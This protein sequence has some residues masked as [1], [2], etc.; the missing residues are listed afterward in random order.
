VRRLV[1]KMSMSVDGYVA[2][3]RGEGDWIIRTGDP[4]GKAWV[5]E[6]LREAGAHVMGRRTYEA[7]KAYWPTSSDPLAELMNSIPK[8]VFSRSAEPGS[9]QAAGAD[10]DEARFLG[11]DLAA[12]VAT[13]KAEPGKDL[14]AQGGV[15]F[16]RSLV[17]AGL[18]DEYRLVRHPVVLGSGLGIF[19]GAEELD[20]TLVDAKTFGSGTQALTYVPR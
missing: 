14:L 19:D 17:G 2:G 5:G 6:T 1:L 16:A 18:V 9:E 15:E 8:V 4:E 11:A 10:W 7:M 20:L 3:P 12:D 13:L